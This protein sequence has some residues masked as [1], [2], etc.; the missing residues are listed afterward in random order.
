MITRWVRISLLLVLIVGGLFLRLFQITNIPPSYYYDEVDNVIL[1]QSLT[2]LGTDITGLWKPIELRPLQTE[3]LN[4][5]LASIFQVVFPRHL[6]NAYFGIATCILLGLLA[7]EL[8]KNKYISLLVMG[9]ML[10]NPWHI[11]VSRTA[12]EA[13]ISFFFQL[14]LIYGI[15]SFSKRKI[16]AILLS[17]IGIF[18][19]FFTYHGAKITVPV[20]TLAGTAYMFYEEF[21]QKKFNWLILTPL[22]FL[23]CLGIFY[24]YQNGISVRSNELIFQSQQLADTV[25]LQRRQS[26]EFP[27]KTVV[28]NKAT[29]LLRLILDRF[30]YVF[31]L[32][33]LF[34]TG[35]ESTFQFSLHVFPYFY[36]SHL[37]LIVL[38]IVIGLKEFRKSTIFVLAILLVS[39]ITSIIT[40][41]LQATF[42]S[43]LTYILLLIFA[44]LGI[45]ALRRPVAK[46]IVTVIII[47]E[48]FYFGLVYFSTYPVIMSDNHEFK[49]R[50]L[51]SYIQ[52]INKPVFI[53]TANPYITGR[54]LVVYN[55]LLPHMTTPERTEFR[56]PRTTTIMLKNITLTNNCPDAIDPNYFYILDSTHQGCQ[57][58]PTTLLTMSSP[59]DSGAYYFIFNDELCSHSA[60]PEY[61]RVTNIKSFNLNQLS[62]SEYC[63]T[64][65]MSSAR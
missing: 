8:F 4:S 18:F 29:V 1:G 48:V 38:G 64:W 15:V 35:Q 11:H 14:L 24:W 62:D 52:R 9:V 60:V 31:D 44:G 43:G 58:N 28:I 61:T 55:K 59:A 17:G 13:V 41:S 10:V 21:R 22:I 36:L 30:I 25:N 6:S 12:Y 50:S 46:I 19:A 32:S 47:F 49:Y 40:T 51:A 23:A 37:V 3:N 56:D 54:A 63:S 39:P 26:L 7:K 34:V 45:Y 65:T 16:V 5:E 53:I 33:R 57:I 2:T 42:R 20:I 27:F